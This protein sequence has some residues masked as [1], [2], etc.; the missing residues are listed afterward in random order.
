MIIHLSLQSS[1]EKWTTNTVIYVEYP[2][3]TDTGLCRGGCRSLSP[4]K[5]RWRPQTC[6]VYVLTGLIKTTRGTYSRGPFFNREATPYWGERGTK[7]WPLDRE[8]DHVVRTKDRRNVRR[9]NVLD[10]RQVVFGGFPRFCQEPAN[11]G[12][13]N[14]GS[15][16]SSLKGFIFRA[17]LLPPQP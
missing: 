3:L 9:E 5:S 2:G 16:V 10:N 8:P 7:S 4:T 6:Y 14:E 11:E 17:V 13:D 1:G 15:R 12:S